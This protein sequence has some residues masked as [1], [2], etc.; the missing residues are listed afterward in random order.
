MIKTKAHVYQKP[1]QIDAEKHSRL[2]AYSDKTGINM[3]RLI[4]DALDKVYKDLF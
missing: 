2:K 1:V 3:K 4:E